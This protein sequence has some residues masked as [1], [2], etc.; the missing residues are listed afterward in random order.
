MKFDYDSSTTSMDSSKTFAHNLSSFADG[1]ALRMAFEKQSLWSI[2][3]AS[4]LLGQLTLCP[5]LDVVPETYNLPGISH[6]C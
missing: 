6:D 1:Y 5:T 4:N 3:T 2:V